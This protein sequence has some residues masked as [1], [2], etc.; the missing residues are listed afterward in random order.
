MNWENIILSAGVGVT[1]G[2]LGFFGGRA[3]NKAETKEVYANALGQEIAN[4]RL[5]I[6][7]WR[8]HS[9]RLE[10]QIDKQD[11]IIQEQN[12]KIND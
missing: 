10:A 4:L 3:K 9:V 11:K 6:E 2:L 7:S 12:V 5:I 8:E 1:T